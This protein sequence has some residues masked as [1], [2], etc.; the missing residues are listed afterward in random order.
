[1]LHARY[2]VAAEQHAQEL[3]QAVAEAEAAA[4]AARLLTVQVRG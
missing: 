3:A 2:E 1:M 4:A